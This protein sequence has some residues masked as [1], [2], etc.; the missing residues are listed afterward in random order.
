MLR[1]YRNNARKTMRRGARNVFAVIT[2]YRYVFPGL[3]PDIRK[4]SEPL[5]DRHSQ[6]I[7]GCKYSI[8]SYPVRIP[9]PS[10]RC[11]LS[12][13]IP[14]LSNIFIPTGNFYALG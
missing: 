4:R 1:N 12:V 6:L 11:L 9:F 3:L 2:V 13:S 8:R 10:D 14:S 7:S 5:T